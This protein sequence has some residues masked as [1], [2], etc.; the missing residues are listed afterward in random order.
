[1]RFRALTGFK[2]I[3]PPDSS[4]LRL[5]EDTAKNVFEKY[6]FEEICLPLLEKSELFLR[7]IGETTEIVEKQM[8]TFQDSDGEQLSLRPEGTASVVRAYIEHSIFQKEPYSKFWYRG[9]MFRHERPQKGRFRQFHQ[10]GAEV[11]GLTGPRIDAEVIEMLMQFFD[12]LKV[13]DL[14]IQVNSLGCKKCRPDYARK[15]A[16]FFEKNANSLCE[17]HQER[18][19]KN[20]FR[21][22]DCKKDPCKD[23]SSR[24]PSI[25]EN[26]CKD[27][28]EHFD[29][30][31]SNLKALGVP[32]IVNTRIVRGLDY[33]TR[34]AFEV[35]SQDL[36]AQN[37]V[38]AGGRYDDLV[39]DI[40]GP[41]TPAIGFA[42]GV[43]RLLS[44]IGPSKEGPRVD[45]FVAAW[46]EEA[47]G[48]GTVL[49]RDLRHKGLKVERGYPPS[50]SEKDPS[51][52]SQMRRAEKLGARYVV[53]VGGEELK[54]GRIVLRDMEKKEQLELNLSTSVDYIVDLLRRS[55]SKSPGG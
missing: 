22:M 36:G 55:P 35:I 31:K 40:G 10:I 48:K 52:K 29:D 26:V 39:K 23:L 6:G 54:R 53:I 28:L 1:M 42:I 49:A 15:L 50:G 9:P 27:C 17:D 32:F 44:L 8:Y 45:V 33:Y 41:A 12:A 47:T 16:S 11:F 2:D 30:F 14:E 19:T 38:V 20:P 43:E 34:T 51:L 46:G 25:L 21:I 5:V 3:L 18:V 24:A 4:S 37:A 13:K 7:S